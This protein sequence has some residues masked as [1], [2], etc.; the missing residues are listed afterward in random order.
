MITGEERGRACWYVLELN[1]AKYQAYKRAI[2][3]GSLDLRTYGTLLQT[4]W[5]VMTEE[6][7][8]KLEQKHN[9]KQ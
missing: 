5:G 4:G 2:A 9:I 1:P 6:L 8:S 7:K 3:Q